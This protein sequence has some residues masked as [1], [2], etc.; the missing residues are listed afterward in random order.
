MEQAGN[1]FEAHEEQIQFAST[2]WRGGGVHDFCLWARWKRRTVLTLIQKMLPAMGK[3]LFLEKNPKM[4]NG[5]KELFAEVKTRHVDEE[6]KMSG[7]IC[8]PHL[9]LR[10]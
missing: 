2:R 4:Y 5:I 8:K 9:Q 3:K 7:K 10:R 6:G 1:R